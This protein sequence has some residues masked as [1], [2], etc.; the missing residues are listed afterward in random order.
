[1][2]LTFDQYL[3]HL[4][5]KNIA[6]N[7]VSAIKQYEETGGVVSYDES[8]DRLR[9]LLSQSEPLNPKYS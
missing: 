2:K 9:Y 4:A 3:R 7:L 1:M 5:Q 6:M 8:M